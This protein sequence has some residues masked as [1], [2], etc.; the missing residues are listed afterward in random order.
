M[1]EEINNEQIIN[2]IT[3]YVLKNVTEE[4]AKDIINK[5]VR[6]NTINL[7][8]FKEGENDREVVND[9][10]VLWKSS[11]F[12][13]R[14]PFNFSRQ[15]Q[16]LNLSTSNLFKNYEKHSI[17]YIDVLNHLGYD[18]LDLP[19][20]VVTSFTLKRNSVLVQFSLDKSLSP[21][22]TPKVS[23][24]FR[25]KSARSF[26][27]AER[28]FNLSY[29]DFLILIVSTQEP[30]IVTSSN[31]ESASISRIDYLEVIT[32]S[33]FLHKIH[34]NDDILKNIGF[35]KPIMTENNKHFITS[36]LDENGNVKP[37]ME[38]SNKFIYETLDN[39]IH[40]DV[41]ETG[42][43]Y[44]LTCLYGDNTRPLY[45]FEYT[46]DGVKGTSYRLK[47]QLMVRFTLSNQVVTDIQVGYYEIPYTL[48]SQEVDFTAFNV[49][50]VLTNTMKNQFVGKHFE[51]LQRINFTDFMYNK[52]LNL[53]AQENEDIY[54][55]L[56]NNMNLD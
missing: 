50:E 47:K 16:N 27:L 42:N 2:E 56:I 23:N 25:N 9:N 32:T 21:I 35:F 11:L 6:R 3:E 10:S 4:S 54:N 36:T 7:E 18:L 24:P 12:H 8:V 40:L 28:T 34:L 49:V 15:N 55:H 26:V 17:G 31:G 52:F 41:V 48:F 45:A 43:S 1:T 5:I 39:T 22:A 53:V 14:T 44:V 29:K 13:N 51:E 20:G 46:I 33:D 19:K 37:Y 30:V 38:L